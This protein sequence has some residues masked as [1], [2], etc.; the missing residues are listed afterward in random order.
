MM[1]LVFRLII[2]TTL[3]FILAIGIIRAQSYDDEGLRDFLMSPT[4]CLPPCFIGIRRAET[5]TD[6]ALTFLQ[7][8]RWIGR[9]DTHHD[10][11]GQV[12]FIKWDWRTG[13]PYGGD[14]QPSRIPA[15]ALNGGQIIIRDGVVFDLDVGMQLPFGEL[16][17]TM[18]ADAEYVYIPPREGNN[19]HLLISRYG[20]LLIRN[21][22][23]AV[24]SCPV[25]MRPLWHAPTVIEFGDLSGV[26]RVNNTFNT[27]HRIDHLTD[28]R[29]IIRRH[30]A[31]G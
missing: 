30:Q 22:I 17:L 29:T 23:D 21:N 6:E 11:D 26:L 28:L 16:Y 27:V 1:R 8:N 14:A 20:D 4:G 2:S 25:I 18:N 24:A 3:L 12:V 9:I 13:F 31:C 5:S 19:G 10:T 7:N 15:Y